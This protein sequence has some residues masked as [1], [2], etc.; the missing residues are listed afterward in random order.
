[1]FCLLCGAENPE[2]ATECTDCG[3][4]LQTGAGTSTTGVALPRGAAHQ[5]HGP[6]QPD[7]GMVALPIIGGVLAVVFGNAAL[8][9]IDRSGE[10]LSGRGMAHGRAHPGL[11]GPGP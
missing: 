8:Q 9:E 4:S 5:Q 7:T 10:Q 3:G 2:G 11:R 1:V 6:G